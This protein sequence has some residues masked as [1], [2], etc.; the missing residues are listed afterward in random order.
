MKLTNNSNS[1]VWW[2]S[3][4]MNDWKQLLTKHDQYFNKMETHKFGSPYNKKMYPS[5][6]LIDEIF[7]AE[8]LVVSN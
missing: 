4:S 3:L 7:I 8:N 2:R 6:E 5:R 1:W